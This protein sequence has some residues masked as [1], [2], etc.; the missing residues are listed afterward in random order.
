MKNNRVIIYLAQAM[1]NLYCDDILRTAMEA[2]EKLEKAGFEVL[3]PVIEEGVPNKHIRLVNSLGR[4]KGFWRRDKECLQK[5]HLMLDL[6][7]MGRSDGVNVEMGLTR[8]AYWKPLVRVHPTLGCVI[9]RLEYDNVCASLDEAIVFMKRNYGTK[10]KLL[11]W[12]LK[13]LRKS[14]LKFVVLQVYFL[15]SLI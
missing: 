10:G 4:L 6:E 11:R 15:W 13:M 9:S 3:S 1:S 5:C 14:L 7:S 2:K 8:F 12:R